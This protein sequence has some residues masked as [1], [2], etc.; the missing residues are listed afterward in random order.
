MRSS[1]VVALL[2]AATTPAS[3]GACQHGKASRVPTA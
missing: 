2:V 1:L 3:A